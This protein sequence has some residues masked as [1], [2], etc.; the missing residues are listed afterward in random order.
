MTPPKSAQ[1]S[2]QTG[3]QKGPPKSKQWSWR[4]RAF[5][6]LVYQFVAIVVISLVA[7]FLASNTLHG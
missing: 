7:W 2:A 4:S 5:R 1:A 3:P 6:G